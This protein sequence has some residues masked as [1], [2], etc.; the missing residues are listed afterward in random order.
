MR[1][2]NLDTLEAPV[3]LHVLERIETSRRQQVAFSHD[4]IRGLA[5]EDPAAIGGPAYQVVADWLRITGPRIVSN[6]GRRWGWVRHRTAVRM[7]VCGAA[8]QQTTLPDTK[9]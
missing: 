9:W 6:S 1:E 2:L 8:R 4:V 3:R 7:F 5:H